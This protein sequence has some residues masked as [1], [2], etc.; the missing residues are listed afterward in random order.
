MPIKPKK[1]AAAIC[2]L[3]LGGIGFGQTSNPPAQT[4]PGTAP[5]QS[6]LNRQRENRRWEQRQQQAMRDLERSKT[7]GAR[8]PPDAEEKPL[9]KEELKKIKA[10]LAPDAEDLAKYENFLADSK[11]GLF[12]LYPNLECMS[13]NLLRVDGVCANF[14]P[15]GGTYSFRTKTHGGL[16]FYSEPRDAFDFYDLRFEDGNLIADGFLAQSIIVPLGDV[17][18]DAVSINSD[19]IGFL[20]DFVPK[21]ANREVRQQFKEL[22]AVVAANNFYYSKKVKAVANVTYAMRIVAYSTQTKIAFRPRQEMSRD[23]V[24]FLKVNRDK[25]VDLTVVFRIIRKDANASISILWKTLRRENAPEIVFEK[26][27]KLVDIKNY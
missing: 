8:R 10:L 22:A 24:R 13:K 11:T 18:L 21:V 14:V 15:G 4:N 1:T 26:D 6:E 9:S 17:P 27:E 5:D 25:R 16:E 20:N 2:L 3:L 7:L 12:R 19:G 23:F